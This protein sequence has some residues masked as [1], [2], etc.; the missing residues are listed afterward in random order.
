[1]KFSVVCSYSFL[2]PE[3]GVFKIQIA[4]HFTK[5]LEYLHLREVI[6]TLNVNSEYL[7]RKVKLSFLP[8]LEY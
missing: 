1:M 8:P 5:V 6:L 4:N 7:V 3:N 2:F